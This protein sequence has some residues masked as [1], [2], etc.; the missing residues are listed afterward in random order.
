MDD[1]AAPCVPW[2]AGPS[3]LTIH[4][5]HFMNQLMADLRQRILNDE[6]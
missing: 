3:L 4:N 5:I 6:V 1:T 2:F